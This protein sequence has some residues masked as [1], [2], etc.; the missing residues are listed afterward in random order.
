M[1]LK[2]Q[3]EESSLSNQVIHSIIKNLSS[4]LKVFKV[5]E[6]KEKKEFINNRI[7]EVEKTLI[8][9]KTI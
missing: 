7:L 8:L 1:N 4:L 6:V 2:V 5:S 9:G 3:T